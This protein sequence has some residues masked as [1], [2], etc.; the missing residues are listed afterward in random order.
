[1]KTRGLK[2]FWGVVCLY[3]I[4][5]GGSLQFCTH[6]PRFSLALSSWKP[7]LEEV[8]RSGDCPPQI[9]DLQRFSKNREFSTAKIPCGGGVRE[10]EWKRAEL[11][12]PT[13]KALEKE[14]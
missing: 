12:E 9:N 1:M 4:R 11:L 14:T 7:L 3:A 6:A 8:A 2:S 13:P 10:K 5:G